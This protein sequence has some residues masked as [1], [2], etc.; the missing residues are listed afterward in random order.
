MFG[1]GV[2]LADMSSKS[3]NYCVPDIS[4]GT[5]LLLLCEAELGKPMH[6]RISFQ[7]DAPEMAKERGSWSTFGKGAVGPSKWKDAVCVNPSLKGVI[8]PSTENSRPGDTG[9]DDS[10]LIYN[11]YICYDEDQVQLRYLFRVNMM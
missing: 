4:D 3:A 5:A 1:K 6:E 10:D 2:Y 7:Y 9:V 8:L 11:E